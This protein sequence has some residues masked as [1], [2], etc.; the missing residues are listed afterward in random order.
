MGKALA[1]KVRDVY[2]GVA[3]ETGAT[4]EEVDEVMSSTWQAVAKF[5]A[6]NRF[7][8]IYLRHLGTF[9]GKEEIAYMIEKTKNKNNE[10]G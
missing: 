3:K 6:E 8:A 4:T 7:N 5:I 10:K 1:N 9:Y 2:H